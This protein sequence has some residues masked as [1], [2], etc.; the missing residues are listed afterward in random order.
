MKSLLRSYGWASSA[1]LAFALVTGCS[2]G[3]LDSRPDASA[4]A[5]DAGAAP[6][7]C[8]LQA[9]TDLVPV[10][11]ASGPYGALVSDGWW[12]YAIQPED[13]KLAR[14]PVNGGAFAPVE[15]DPLR[16][17][18]FWP[19]MIIAGGS[20]GIVKVL[21]DGV[22][23]TRLVDGHDVSGIVID[24]SNVFWSESLAGGGSEIWTVGVDGADARRLAT[25][26]GVVASLSTRDGAL[27]WLELDGNGTSFSVVGALY[28]GTI[29]AAPVVITGTPT[30]ALIT[31]A[32][33]YVSAGTDILALSWGDTAPKVFASDQAAVTG[34]TL[35]QGRLYWSQNVDCVTD[36]NIGNGSTVCGG[37]IKSMPIVGGPIE[38]IVGSDNARSVYHDDS[39]LYWTTTAGQF[40]LAAPV[41][42]RGAPVLP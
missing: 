20:N 21:L 35:A 11:S 6:A 33:V 17:I 9:A 28:D 26:P 34:L 13:R 4:D 7:I 10:T 3:G 12:L 15:A 36:P 5:A 18:A 42:I 31:P 41:G 24:Q 40:H 27:A 32:V 38:E 2:T 22:T 8:Q 37:V 19:G 14:V 29:P 25:R 23:T 30:A 39:C 16:A 1:P